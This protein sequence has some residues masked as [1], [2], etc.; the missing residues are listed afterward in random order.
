VN[1]VPGKDETCMRGFREVLKEKRWLMSRRIFGFH[2]SAGDNNKRRM[3]NGELK[4][5]SSPF[6]ILHSPFSFFTSRSA[7]T[8]AALTQRT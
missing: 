8:T 2:F 3:E 6:S 4:R 7:N 1:D 5:Y